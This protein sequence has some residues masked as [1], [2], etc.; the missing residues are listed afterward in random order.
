MNRHERPGLEDEE[1]LLADGSCF[2]RGTDVAARAVR[3]QVRASGVERHADQLDE[4]ARQNAGGP[5]VGRHL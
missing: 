2:E 1:N 5:W 3:I 4:L